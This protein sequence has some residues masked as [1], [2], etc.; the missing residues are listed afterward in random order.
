MPVQCYNKNILALKNKHHLSVGILR[1]VY[2]IKV[3][4]DE[5]LSACK[6]ASKTLSKNF[7]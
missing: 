4:F 7:D 2:T 1:P 5:V 6:H 3:L